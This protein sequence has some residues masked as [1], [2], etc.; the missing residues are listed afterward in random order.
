MVIHI[1][2]NGDTIFSV[3]QQY[4]VNPDALAINNGVFGNSNLA[5]G[6]S[7]VIVFPQKTHIVKEGETLLSIAQSYGVSIIQLYRNNL[8][9]EGKPFIFPGMQLVIEIEDNKIGDYMTGGYAYPY[10]E[11]DLLDAQLPF[12]GALMPF[13][14]GFKPDGS[15]VPI[16][17][18]V[19]IERAK[20]YGTKPVMHLS[21]LTEGDVFS[22]ELATGFLNNKAVWNTL[23]NNALSVM[24]QKG[25]YGLDVDFEFLGAE[26]A[27]NYV[28]FITFARGILNPQG[29]P[30]MV[31]LAPKTSVDQPGVLYQGHDYKGLGQAAN[32]VLLMTYEW[33]YTY[34]PPMA[35][36]PI[37][38]VTRVVEFALTQI[39]SK[40]MF[41]GISNYG[42][43]FVLPYVPGESKATSISLIQANELAVRTGATIMYDEQ[44][45]APFFRYFEN[46]VEHI[47]WYEDARSISARLQLMKTYNLRGALYWNLNRPNPQ[48]LVVINALLNLLEF[49]LF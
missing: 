31:A 21:T 13:T 26:N 19:M 2:K 49:N 20:L 40:K 45:Q 38:P 48:N 22:V 17:D 14:Y 10:I 25:Y 3:A 46:G 41:L 34:G 24:K 36:S 32:A 9:L 42:Y 37:Q 11:T 15:L 7:L 39:D 44:A 8:I 12:M 23:V 1:V 16:D 30:I 6:Q 28:E 18:T 47:V 33:G 35:I 4:G 43:D 27:A 29:Y 5:I